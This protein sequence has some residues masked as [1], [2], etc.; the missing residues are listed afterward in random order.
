[1]YL[2]ILCFLIEL[3]RLKEK[4]GLRFIKLKFLIIQSPI[5]HLFQ[6]V[7]TRSELSLGCVLGM[8]MGEWEGARGKREKSR[9][10]RDSRPEQKTLA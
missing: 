1:M 7:Q 4:E 3:K 5:K 8:R 6:V 9:H 2:F 10:A